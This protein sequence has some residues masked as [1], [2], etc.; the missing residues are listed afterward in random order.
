M[1]ED[2]FLSGGDDGRLVRVTR[3]GR[4][5]GDRRPM[6]HELGGARRRARERPARRRRRQGG[7][8]VDAAGAALKSLTH[9]SSVGGIAFDAKGKRVAASHYNGASLWFVAAKE[10]K[11]RVL[12]WKGSHPPSPS[13]RTARMW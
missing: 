6:R 3:R 2:G 5:R 9:P 10:D 8:S 11:P 4:S 13:A 7:A 12:E 1:R